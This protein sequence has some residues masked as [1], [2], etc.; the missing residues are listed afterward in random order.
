MTSKSG[1]GGQKLQER[2]GKTAFFQRVDTEKKY[3]IVE[4]RTDVRLVL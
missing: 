2:F 1:S 4:F 3:S